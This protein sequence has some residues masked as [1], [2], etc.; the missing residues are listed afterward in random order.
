MIN[1][2]AFTNFTPFVSALVKK[3]WNGIFSIT[4]SVTENNIDQ[5]LDS[6]LMKY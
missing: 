2:N 6:L 4:H 3:D 1:A 5:N